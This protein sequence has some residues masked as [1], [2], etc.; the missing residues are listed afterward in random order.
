MKFRVLLYYDVNPF[1][2]FYASPLSF[3]LDLH[4]PLS[5]ESVL[6]PATSSVPLATTE[7]R[8]GRRAE[9]LFSC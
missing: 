6:A 4:L 1:M 5:N 3:M 9:I 2:Y 8:I 7:L